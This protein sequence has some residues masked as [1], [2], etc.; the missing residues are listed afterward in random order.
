[1]EKNK[2]LRDAVDSNDP[3][4]S[5]GHQIVTARSNNREIPTWALNRSKI[6]AILLCSFPK[7]KTDSRQR[8]AAARWT[9]VIQLYFRMG[10]TYTQVAEEIGS[11]PTKIDSVIRSIKRAA[12]GRSANGSGLLGRKR[13]RPKKRAG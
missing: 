11:S 9:W 6:Q 13:G 10:Y 4:V 8:N 7:L 12:Q 2:Q 3:F 5:R 1:M